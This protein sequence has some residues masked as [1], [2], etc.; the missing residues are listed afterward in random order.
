M[1][2]LTENSSFLKEN[3]YSLTGDARSCPVIT[4]SEG[5]TTRN[6]GPAQTGHVCTITCN[7]GY[8]LSGGS[9]TLVCQAN[10]EWSGSIPTC[11]GW[12]N[13]FA[14]KWF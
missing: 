3:N 1:Q 6:C 5:S 10:G 12:F 8:T 4:I 11:T 13:V 2:Q 9:G 14:F 7:A